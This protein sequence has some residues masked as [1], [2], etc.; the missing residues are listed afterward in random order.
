MPHLE[1][2]FHQQTQFQQN[3]VCLVAR[4]HPRIQGS[5]SKEQFG[6]EGHLSVKT[7]GTSHSIVDKTIDKG[8]VPRRNVLQLPSFLGLGRIVAEATFIATVPDKYASTVQASEALQ[9]LPCPFDMP[10][11]AVKRHWRERFH[12][13][14]AS[15][16][17]RATFSTLFTE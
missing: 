2:G 15:R 5:L 3:F 17:L 1:A 8:G 12:A 10:S 16:W 9:L 7:S 11:F 4:G 13:D 6:V 14:P